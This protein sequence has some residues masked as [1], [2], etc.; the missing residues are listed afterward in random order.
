MRTASS[1]CS[2]SIERQARARSRLNCGNKV[3]VGFCRGLHRPGVSSMAASGELSRHR[4]KSECTPPSRRSFGAVNGTNVLKRTT[5]ACEPR[6]GAADASCESGMHCT[7]MTRSR[8]SEEPYAAGSQTSTQKPPSSRATRAD[9]SAVP[10]ALQGALEAPR[11]QVSP[12]LLASL[13]AAN[14]RGWACHAV[15]LCAFGSL[16]L[17]ADATRRLAPEVAARLHI[18]L[19]MCV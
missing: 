3:P 15:L 10:P 6:S 11:G 4:G 12:N 14:D 5:D 17:F 19:S 2:A 16:S 9:P 1:I 13:A 7:V 18:V 8:S